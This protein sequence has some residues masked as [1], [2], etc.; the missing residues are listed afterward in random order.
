MMPHGNVN[1][2]LDTRELALFNRQA[3]PGVFL[4]RTSP[5]LT[6]REKGLVEKHLR[7]LDADGSAKGSPLPDKVVGYLLG[8]DAYVTGFMSITDVIG[9]VEPQILGVEKITTTHIRYA[10]HMLLSLVA[11]E[12]KKSIEEIY[13]EC[14]S[15][16]NPIAPVSDFLSADEKKPSP[17]ELKKLI[18]DF[19]KT[20]F[21]SGTKQEVP[22]AQKLLQASSI[23]ANDLN[24]S[25][26]ARSDSVPVSLDNS[27]NHKSTDKLTT[28]AG[29]KEGLFR[30][31]SQL[32]Q[33]YGVRY[34]KWL[35]GKAPQELGLGT[36]I[37][38]AR[39]VLAARRQE[40]L[41]TAGR[42]LRSTAS[43]TP[44]EDLASIQN[45]FVLSD[46]NLQ[47]DIADKFDA[48]QNLHHYAVIDSQRIV[49]K[50]L[51]TA[52]GLSDKAIFAPL[53]E[54]EGQEHSPGSPSS[55]GRDSYSSERSAGSRHSNQDSVAEGS[56][57]A[58]S[59]TAEQGSSHQSSV[60]DLPQPPAPNANQQH[61]TAQQRAL[62]DILPELVETTDKLRIFYN[63]TKS[64]DTER[65]TELWNSYRTLKTVT[66][67]SQLKGQSVDCNE[68]HDPEQSELSAAQIESL[69]ERSVL[70]EGAIAN[71]ITYLERLL[72]NLED[73]P[74]ETFER[75]SSLELICEVP[76][77]SKDL[78][79]EIPDKE[80][81]IELDAISSVGGPMSDESPSGQSS[82]AE[83]LASL[84][85][86]YNR[87]LQYF[88]NAL[89]G[90]FS[91]PTE[92]TVPSSAGPERSQQSPEAQRS[93]APTPLATPSSI[94][95]ISPNSKTPGTVTGRSLKTV[96]FG[97]PEAIEYQVEAE[98]RQNLTGN[99]PL[100]T[101]KTASGVAIWIALLIREGLLKMHS[102]GVSSDSALRHL[103]ISSWFGAKRLVHAPPSEARVLRLS[104]MVLL[105][106]L[107][108]KGRGE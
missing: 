7:K 28:D 18:S 96:S 53:L 47:R 79:G 84:T 98:N 99:N 11:H 39:E 19:E 50:Y 107:R 27:M 52:A 23:T 48:N 76:L 3:L 87:L 42:I 92:E 88:K 15:W 65:R 6:E 72:K 13:D 78:P 82:A 1:A 9:R 62:V 95:R 73:R 94:L 71:L 103:L 44:L 34:V 20:G 40:I 12:Q 33:S 30:K 36:N 37:K 14:L 61:Q 63:Q 4:S 16:Q 8:L 38:A 100:T 75:C 45:F 81:E 10:F 49:L 67:I 25:V 2:I 59:E 58:S 97:A 101:V 41:K 60:E 69:G 24:R 32:K 57:V 83:E 91:D 74:E 29:I 90:F 108:H 54:L 102:E 46:E 80:S 68:E 26:E 55:A 85:Q 66:L 89:S 21:W 64:Q 70:D 43:R 93:G 31:I 56:S 77:Y 51:L 17:L 86:D 35:L 106:F 104:T 5:I 22:D 105:G